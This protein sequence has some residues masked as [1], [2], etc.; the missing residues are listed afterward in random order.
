VII[1]LL[2]C[3]KISGSYDGYVTV[4]CCVQSGC[5]H[6]AT[7]LFICNHWNGTVLIL[8]AQKLLQVRCPTLS[9]YFFFIIRPHH[10][11]TYVDVA[12]RYQ[13]SS[14]ICLSI[15]QSVRL[16]FCLSH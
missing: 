6:D 11:T 3:K 5:C 2:L 16:L 9:V 10:S 12:Y 15:G 8:P 4:V 7:L 14:V 1:R 13:P